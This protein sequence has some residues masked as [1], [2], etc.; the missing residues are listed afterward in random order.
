MNSSIKK[1]YDYAKKLEKEANKWDNATVGTIK[2]IKRLL[3]EMVAKEYK[4]IADSVIQEFYDSYEPEFYEPRSYTLFNAFKVKHGNGWVDWKLTSGGLDSPRHRASRELIFDY[5][6]ERGWHG[7]SPYIKK[8][9]EDVWG[10]H[11]NPGEPYYRTPND[12]WSSWG[13]PAAVWG[14]S[15]KEEIEK[16]IRKRSAIGWD[17]EQMKIAIEAF[18]GVM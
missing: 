8:G 13:K 15:P 7:G 3:P 6:I 9:K 17:K 12:I 14:K 5:M 4:S 16:R 1:M 2:G 18:K 11:P 10:K